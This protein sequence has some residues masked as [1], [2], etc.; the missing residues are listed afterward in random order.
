[1]FGFKDYKAVADYV[2][3]VDS[4]A[5][6]LHYYP[7]AEEGNRHRNDYYNYMWDM[8]AAIDA[9]VLD[10]KS[11]EDVRLSDFGFSSAKGLTT[12]LSDRLEEYYNEI[13]NNQN[14]CNINDFIL[15]NKA[16]SCKAEDGIISPN[17]IHLCILKETDETIELYKL[18]FM[19]RI[20]VN[21]VTAKQVKLIDV[22]TGEDMG[23]VASNTPVVRDKT[24]TSK[25]FN[26]GT[27]FNDCYAH[28]CLDGIKNAIADLKIK[29]CRICHYAFAQSS[30]DI[31]WF[32]EKGLKVPNICMD[33][34][35]HKK[36]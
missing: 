22:I 32:T 10:G 29:E 28:T 3:V 4:Y 17:A 27:A 7:S 13:K 6:A 34:R 2:S 18:K 31:N 12:A 25:A 36:K 9:V 1:M 16:D 15:I 21:T 33:C 19:G 8:M 24:L 23:I 35:K 30:V 20:L 5:I 11:Y 26:K 14:L